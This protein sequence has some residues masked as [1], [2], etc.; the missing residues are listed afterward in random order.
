VKVDTTTLAAGHYSTTINF[1]SNGGSAPVVVRLI[2]AM[3]THCFDVAPQSL[4][5]TGAAYQSDPPPQQVTVKNCGTATG[6]WSASPSTNDGANWLNISSNGGPLDS[7]AKQNITVT[8][9]NLAAKLPN[10]TYTGQVTFMMGSSSISVQV[11]LTVHSV[12]IKTDLSSISFPLT[13]GPGYADSL[14]VMSP[15]HNSSFV[16]LTNC[17]DTAGDWSGSTATTDGKGW[18]NIAST[19]GSLN[20]GETADILI[21]A[22][23]S[24]LY[25]GTYSGSITFTI[26]TS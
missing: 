10:R 1:S 21:G 5:F 4:S 2:V 26:K 12:C 20:S 7:G 8:A 11:I 24:I 17:G 22:N 25:P 23:S 18:L 14:S 15:L 3:Q 9:S 13:P 6:T 16:R 19:N